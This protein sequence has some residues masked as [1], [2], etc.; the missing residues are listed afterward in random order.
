MFSFLL[1]V[2]A[3]SPLFTKVWRMH[4]LLT[5]PNP[6]SRAQLNNFQAVLY[7]LP[8]IVVE[9]LIL[10]IFSFAD[11]PRQ[12]ELL[13]VGD[14]IGE[15][16]ISCAHR[17]KAFLITQCLY[18]GILVGIGCVLAYNTKDLDPRFG[19]AKQLGMCFF[20]FPLCCWR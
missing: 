11:P 3:L 16:Q 18:D 13:G 15:Q 10:T 19:E 17:T 8:A 6:R 2:S 20:P 7:T 4:K 5:T 14:G 9:L 1:M 12:T